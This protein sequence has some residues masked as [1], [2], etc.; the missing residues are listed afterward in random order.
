MSDNAVVDNE[1]EQKQAAPQAQSSESLINP[2]PVVEAVQAEPAKEA[3]VSWLP[4]EY[5]DNPSVNK[6]PNVQ[7]ALKSYIELEKFIGSSVRIPDGSNPELL[8][9][10][11][12]KIGR[13]ETPDAYKI[14]LSDEVK[15]IYNIESEEHKSFLKSVH[16]AGLTNKQADSIIQWYIQQESEKAKG[17]Q[18]E[19]IAA[20]ETLEK[21]WGADKYQEKIG[22]INKTLSEYQKVYGKESMDKL[23]KDFGRNPALV[24][25][26]DDLANVVLSSGGEDQT[27]QPKGPQN[28]GMT[29]QQAY[30]RIA[31]IKKS[32]DFKNEKN[33][34][35]DAAVL[36]M[37]K[38]YEALES[39]GELGNR[40]K[41]AN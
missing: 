20:K 33:R 6:F 38:A 19:Q 29:V 39:Y 41:R 7:E 34:G 22:N 27:P 15:G 8:E 35:H 2:A 36:E 17:L 25:I 18:Q 30:D 21:V 12:N 11:Y 26:L 4:E 9:K 13:P 37:H 40:N 3:V 5:K 16:A 14:E 32:D 1:S 23:I 31:E 10:F 24:G 28:Y